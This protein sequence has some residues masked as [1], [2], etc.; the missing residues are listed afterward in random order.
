M[1]YF[2]R[3]EKNH[4]EEGIQEPNRSWFK[5]YLFVQRT[6]IIKGGNLFLWK[7]RN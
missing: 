3:K 6:D 1:V 4:E 5:N 7:K 2:D